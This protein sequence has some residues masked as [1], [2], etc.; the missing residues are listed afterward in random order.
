[1]GT[2]I[3]QFI[4]YVLVILFIIIWIDRGF[5]G[6]YVKVPNNSGLVDYVAD[7]SNLSNALYALLNLVFCFLLFFSRIRTSLM[8]SFLTLVSLVIGVFY[9]FEG[10]Y[11]HNDHFFPLARAALNPMFLL[12]ICAAFVVYDER[13]F[14]K[15][16]RVVLFTSILFLLLGLYVLLVDVQELIIRGNTPL[17]QF[18]T[19]AFWG[20]VFYM[21][22]KEKL[23]KGEYIVLL[24]GLLCC[25][26]TSFIIASRSWC[27]QGIISLVLL[28]IIAYREKK[29]RRLVVILCVVFA[30][31][32]IPSLYETFQTTDWYDRWE[33]K[34]GQDTR[35]EQYVEVFDQ[36]PLHYFI[37]GNGFHTSWLQGNVSYNYIDNQTVMFLYRYGIIPTVTYYLFLLIPLFRVLR[38]RANY[39]IKPIILLMLWIFAING[40]SVFNTLNW[41]WANF[42]IAIACARLWSQT[43][44]KRSNEQYSLC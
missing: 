31:V 4:L 13:F 43:N 40:L 26:V 21:S 25:T 10:I 16:L 34:M 44:K 39:S 9:F 35:S 7:A 30:F 24:M 5:S 41:D 23:S 1:M 12:I 11:V 3:K 37:V 20:F 19:G 36:M 27:I 32:V 38:N 22:F 28:N 2:R 17:L 33:D 15:L 42:L 8:M 6:H 14:A 29:L 18:R